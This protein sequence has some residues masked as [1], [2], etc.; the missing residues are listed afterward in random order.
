MPDIHI[1]KAQPDDAQTILF[2]VKELAA[3]EKAEEQVTA[4]VEDIQRTM[5]GVDSA[6]AALICEIDGKP[7]G[8]AVYYF[9]Y[10]T[11]LG[12]YGLYLEDL[13]IAE[14][15]RGTGAGKALLSYLARIAVEKKCSRFEFSVLDWNR[16]A[17]EFYESQGARAQSEWIKYRVSG[18]ELAALAAAD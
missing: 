7:A 4:S 18:N 16:P 2:F 11:W 12:E 10:S 8:H 1:R 17:I 15:F 14:A 6:V 3:C 9:N 5:F 13:Y